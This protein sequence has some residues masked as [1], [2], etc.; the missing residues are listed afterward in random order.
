MKINS[1]ET[2]LCPPVFISVGTA[3]FVFLLA[4]A[5]VIYFE[6]GPVENLI[7]VIPDDAFYY[8]QVARHRAQDG[9]W[10]FDGTAP[11]SG[12]HVLYG[13]FLFFI[14]SI[15]PDLHW[16]TLF[17]IIGILASFT[18]A[19]SAYF[20]CQTVQSFFG[21]KSAIVAVAP[22]V[23]APTI[24]QATVMMESWLV[25]FFS[26]LTLFVIL[27]IKKLTTYWFIACFLVGLLGSLSRAD[28][29]MWPAL[30]F[31]VLV[32]TQPIKNSNELKKSS[33]IL[34]GAIVGVLMLFL[35]NYFISGHLF[36]ASAE[37]KYYWSAL[38]GHPLASTIEL[39]FILAFP[40]LGSFAKPIGILL[41]TILLAFTLYA[42]LTKLKQKNEKSVDISTSVFIGCAI[43]ILSYVCFYRYNSQAIQVWYFANFIVPIAFCSC[44]IYYYSFKSNLVLPAF[45]IFISFN[46]LGLATL[47]HIP[48][49]HQ[50]SMM[51]A[52]IYLKKSN[53]NATFGS[54]NAGIFSYFSGRPLVNLDGLINDEVFPFIK[55]NSLLDYIK[56]RN[57]NYL[58]DYEA[59]LKTNA[60]RIKGGYDDPQVDNCIISFAVIDEKPSGWGSVTIYKIKDDCLTKI[61]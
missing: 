9:F 40:F 39:L 2:L 60:F 5:R 61:P 28:Y 32:L 10:T 29:G 27:K 19:G 8:I 45:F 6:I 14:Y 34:I 44:A 37:V 3:L 15:T 1:N 43:T 38:S 54:W 12:F 33:W 50:A 55:S 53:I 24:V 52:G 47:F 57:I 22:F 17:L 31:L 4:M 20:T 59:M 21:R 58:V 42:A 46:F 51:K 36:Q 49:P 56:K 23:I 30:I 26:A 18:I 7:G 35:N 11:A 41:C 25:L 16:K 13:Y 48:Y